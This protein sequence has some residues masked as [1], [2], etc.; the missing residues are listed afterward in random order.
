MPKG[1]CSWCGAK[2]PDTE[3]YHEEYGNCC[4]WCDSVFNRL[5]KGVRGKKKN[6][7]GGI[8][9]Y[10]IRDY[11]NAEKEAIFTEYSEKRLK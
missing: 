10:K 4:R 2:I 9:E 11:T 8:E 6:S 7:W 1:T 5:L 3:E